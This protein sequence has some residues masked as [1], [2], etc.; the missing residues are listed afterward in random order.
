MKAKQRLAAVFVTATLVIPLGAQEIRFRT[1]LPPSWSESTAAFAR[2]QDMIATEGIKNVLIR[3]WAQSEDGSLLVLASQT[4]P[5][6][7]AVDYFAGVQQEQLIGYYRLDPKWGSTKVLESEDQALFMAYS[8]MRAIPGTAFG[9]PAGTIAL[10]ATI[11]GAYFDKSDGSFKYVTFT[12]R[13]RIAAASFSR[14]KPEI[15]AWLRSIHNASDAVVLAPEYMPEAMEWLKG[16]KLFLQSERARN[17]VEEELRTRRAAAEAEIK[18]EKAKAVA[19]V[20]ALRASWRPPVTMPS[21]PP[22]ENDAA[23]SIHKAYRQA[24]GRS[25]AKWSMGL[26]AI[27]GLGIALDADHRGAAGTRDGF[28]VAA[29]ALAL[30]SALLFVVD[31][32][33]R[34]DRPAPA[35]ADAT[36]SAAPASQT[37]PVASAPTA[38]PAAPR[39]NYYLQVGSFSERA[40]ADRERDKEAFKPYGAV[41][42]EVIRE[43]KPAYLVLVGGSR[44]LESVRRVQKTL[45]LRGGFIVDSRGKPITS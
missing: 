44:D 15:I 24:V 35:R 33:S 7:F 30:G 16:Q 12:V 19:E 9:I 8:E 41:V 29:G 5:R 32:A 36:R 25:V 13:G 39:H 27:G 42:M 34:P 23:V 45:D 43:K 26:A 40:S 28:F 17:A 18:A 20:E 4:Y 21:A 31:A 22:T 37:A 1:A 11:P 3:A 6:Y 38:L 2:G 10:W 14:L